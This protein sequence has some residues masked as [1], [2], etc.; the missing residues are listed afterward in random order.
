MEFPIFAP[1]Q[2]VKTLQY[3]S[4]IEV[5]S[6]AVR[7]RQN[8]QGLRTFPETLRPTREVCS[9]KIQMATA[10]SGTCFGLGIERVVSEVSDDATFTS[11]R[12]IMTAGARKVSVAPLR[13]LK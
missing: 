10:V 5:H 1:L 6:T 3:S 8:G 11:R 2:H 13:T 12:V 4:T 7:C 9:I